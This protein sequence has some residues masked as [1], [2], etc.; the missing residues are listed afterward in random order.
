[1]V[2]VKLERRKNMRSIQARIK[3]I[4]GNESGFTLVEVLVAFVI[5]MIGL[6]GLTQTTS[7]SL[8]LTTR[9]ST[10]QKG[11]DDLVSDYNSGTF[12]NGNEN[13]TKNSAENELELSIGNS[14]DKDTCEID[15]NLNTYTKN[16][17]DKEYMLQ[18]YTRNNEPQ[19][20]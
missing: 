18:D 10:I 4:F 5:L 3:S 9:A 8:N 12:G 17:N 7:F 1:M 6:A 15:G 2:Q 16:I 13:A 11:V 14:G 20:P 19:E